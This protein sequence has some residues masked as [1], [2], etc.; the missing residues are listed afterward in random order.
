M[1]C[2]GILIIGPKRAVEDCGARYRSYRCFGRPD[3][4]HRTSGRYRNWIPVLPLKRYCLFKSLF[5]AFFQATRKSRTYRKEE[6]K[7][8]RDFTIVRSFV[9]LKL[10]FVSLEL[11]L[12]I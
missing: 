4:F 9:S 5:K 3:P 8:K 11:H 6:I 2:R 12:C 10:E 1:F 7:P